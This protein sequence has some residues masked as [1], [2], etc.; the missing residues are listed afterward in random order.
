VPWPPSRRALTVAAVLVIALTLRVAEV[1]RT[2]YRPVN[3]A[4]SYLTLASEVA[5]IGDYSNSHRS[6]AGA[7]GTRGP[8]AYFPPGYPYFLAAVDLLDGHTS[9]RGA[10]V[11][12]ARISQAALGTVTVGLVGLVA[13][14][15]FG[16]TIGLIALVLAA[17][18]PVLI[19]LSGTLVAENLLI[20]FVLAAVWAA[21][22]ARRSADRRYLWTAATG[23]FTGLAALTHANGIVIVVPLLFAVWT[24]R[25]RVAWRALAA[26]A[27][28]IAV[29]AV[30]LAPWVIRNAIVLHR[31]IPITDET[32]ITL[33]GTYNPASA[34]NHQVPYKWRLYDGIAQDKRLARRSGT[35]TEAALG[36]KL[37]SQ[38]LHYIGDHPLAPLKV[39]YH[40]TLRMFELEGSFAWHAS[41]AAIDL[42]IAVARIGV[43]SFWLLCALAVIGAFTRAV[44]DAPKWLW[45][46]PILFALTIVFVNVE[47]PRFREPVDPFLILLAACAVGA[48][49]ARLRSSPVGRDHRA[50]APAGGGEPVEV[51]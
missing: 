46:V 11:D 15:A 17:I 22:R 30:T 31:F 28:L 25:P 35:L 19:G 7:G 20:A 23:L 5:H 44:R 37:Q 2:T 12:P 8:S 43:I 48:L 32:G 26:P 47:T 4:G 36:D 3:D 24:D 21:L 39:A 45:W 51:V 41:A 27:L 6:G 14:E 29:T 33:V 40:N 13:L 16:D 49:L 18:Y 38:A 34:A 42:P 9:R 10:A 1:Q 50:P